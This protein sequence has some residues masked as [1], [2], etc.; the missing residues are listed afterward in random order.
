MSSDRIK[1][2]FYDLDQIKQV[3]IMEICEKFGIAVVNKGGNPWCKVRPER[4]PS[5]IL[6][7]ERNTFHDFGSGQ[8]SDSIGLVS[9]YFNVDRGEAIRLIADQFSISPVNPRGGLSDAE[10]TSWEY[11]K[12]GLIGTVA[13]KNFDFDI[14]RQ[15]VN[16]VQELYFRYGMPMNVL[17]KNN[18]QIYQKL[19]WNRAIPHVK[20]LRANYYT[21]IYT[22]YN[23]AKAMGSE[24]VFFNLAEKGE[25]ADLIKELQAAERILARAC[26]GTNI[27]SWPVGE[28][29]PVTDLKTML[30]GEL[31]ISLGSVSRREMEK[32]SEKENSPKRYQSVDLAAFLVGQIDLT[33][34][35]YTASV[36]KGTAVIC[37]LDKDRDAIKPIL[38]NFRVSKK[39]DLNEKIAEAEQR[40]PTG[41]TGETHK[42]E[43]SAASS[44]KGEER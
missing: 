16:R 35:Q 39:K 36:R 38:N 33:G 11:E 20:A 32:L 27:T 17:K 21:E 28:Y 43:M 25:F 15:G 4:T 41:Q 31:K 8:T 44:G 5:V 23:L 22:K 34:F 13:T 10:L 2:E 9:T 24:Q 12:I 7:P 18:P 1:K 14:E 26:K 40:V 19:L 42:H 37:Y 6:H 29:D 3:P 30:E